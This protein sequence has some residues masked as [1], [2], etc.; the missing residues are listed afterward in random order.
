MTR[1]S[2]T[3]KAGESG[4]SLG[5]P[6]QP[7][8]RWRG[9]PSPLMSARDGAASPLT[10]SAPTSAWRRRLR[11][12]RGGET[13]DGGLEEAVGAGLAEFE[14]DG[15]LALTRHRDRDD[16][17]LDEADRVG[18]P[19]ADPDRLVLGRPLVEEDEGPAPAQVDDH[20]VRGQE[21]RLAP[22]PAEPDLRLHHLVPRCPP[23][24]RRRLAFPQP[25]QPQQAPALSPGRSGSRRNLVEADLPLLDRL[26]LQGRRFLPHR[27]LAGQ[28][29]PSS[30][31]GTHS[32]LP[33]LL[34]PRPRSPDPPSRPCPESPRPPPASPNWLTIIYYINI[35]YISIGLVWPFDR[36]PA[37][38][39]VLLVDQA[40]THG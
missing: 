39:R 20:G 10:P 23:A 24:L 9:W 8:V 35:Y 34:E 12:I 36:H 29:P 15:A 18:H 31:G 4:P 21:P 33:P 11:G 22:P 7:P 38:A 32:I 6:R 26:R 28:I 5:H 2:M 3:S 37:R 40:K 1:P 25:E 19:Q 16:A 13:A 30:P 17:G 27:F 14:P